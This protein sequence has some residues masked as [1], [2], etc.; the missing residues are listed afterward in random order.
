M[1]KV[2]H[3]LMNTTEGG[4]GGSG[5]TPQAPA[6]P[7]APAT[8]QAG[9][10]DPLSFYAQGNQP[11]APQSQGNPA[12]QPQQAAAPAQ[13]AAAA[14]LVPSTSGYGQPPAPAAPAPSTSG[15]G[16]PPAPEVPPVPPAAAVPPVTSEPPATPEVPPPVKHDYT[17]LN[18]EGVNDDIKKAY[19]EY[20]EA[21]NLDPETAQKFVDL[22][23]MEIKKVGEMQTQRKQA[24]EAQKKTWVDNLKAHPEFGGNNFDNSV[25]IT[26]KYIREFFPGFNKELTT[27]KSML[28]DSIMLDFFARAKEAYNTGSMAPTEHGDSSSGAVGD[29]FNRLDFYN[30]K[31]V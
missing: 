5:Q 13:P 9:G 19:I 21:N 28:P 18:T 16:Q 29:N 22:K 4:S 26:E 2:K 10:S 23:K 12:G 17:K 30:Q 25:H 1:F 24:Y 6:S 27:N 14:P 31:S 8:P 20:A 15:Y 7:T 3:V 11:P